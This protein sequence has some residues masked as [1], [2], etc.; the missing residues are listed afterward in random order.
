[1]DRSDAPRHCMRGQAITE[2]IVLVWWIMV[3]LGFAAYVFLAGVDVGGQHVPGVE[4][5]YL[6]VIKVVSLPFP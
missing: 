2:Y 3:G 4:E 5:F 1:M 6:N